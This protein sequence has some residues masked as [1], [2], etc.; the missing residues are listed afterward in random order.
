MNLARVIA[1]PLSIALGLSV[2]CSDPPSP[3]AQGALTLT[4]SPG[5]SGGQCNAT[6]PERLFPNDP[7]VEDR[8]GCSLATPNQC[9]KPD[10]LVVVDGASS[11]HVSCTVAANGDKFDVNLVLDIQPNVRF[12]ATGQIGAT[13]GTLNISTSGQ[14]LSG[15]GL[16]GDCTFE[17]VP[18]FGLVKPG[19]I[20]GHYNCPTFGDPKSPSGASCQSDGRFIFENC[21]S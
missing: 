8:L 13:G 17:V 2:G 14:V 1:A 20:W 7:A 3:P 18:N 12:Q 19:A 6:G 4:V 9:G 5:A 15:N 10:D 11:S 21:G 16:S